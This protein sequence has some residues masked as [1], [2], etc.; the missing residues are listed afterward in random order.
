MRDRKSG[1]VVNIGSVAGQLGVSDGAIY[2]I[3][4]AAVTHNTRCL[5][6]ELKQHGVRVN[7]VAP[8]PTKTAW[9]EATRVVDPEM[10]N[11]N[12]AS[13]VRYGE[14]DEIADTVAFLV[15]DQA[16]FI[17]GQVLCVDGGLVNFPS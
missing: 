8:G 1:V 2:G 17:N 13:L 15:S 14:P 5:A 6:V 10:M 9:F 7:C 12:K 11:S 16:K 3:L 4:K